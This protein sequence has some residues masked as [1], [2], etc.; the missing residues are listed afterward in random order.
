MVFVHQRPAQRFRLRQ[1]HIDPYTETHRFI[2]RGNCDAEDV[3]VT[4]C[5]RGVGKIGQVD[6]GI[7]FDVRDQTLYVGSQRD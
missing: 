5:R 1:R 4:A 2:G 6:T 7:G 3:V